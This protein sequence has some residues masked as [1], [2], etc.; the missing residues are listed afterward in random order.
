MLANFDTLQFSASGFTTKR[1]VIG[2]ADTTVDVILDA[3]DRWGGLKN[4]PARSAGCG[5]PTTITSGNK[6]ITSGGAAR[7]YIVDLP[8]NYN[9]DKPYRLIYVSHGMGGQANDVATFLN[10]FGVK[11]EA[12]AAKDPAVLIAMN[13]IGGR[14]GESDHV[15]FDDVTNFVFKG[16]CID[17]TR[18]FV[19]GMSMGG[20]FSYSLSTDRQ[21]RIRAGVGIAPTNYNIWLPNP[22]LK[23]P[24]PWMQT[25]GN[26]DGFC[27]WVY[28]A[29]QKLGAKF[30]A[31]EKAADNGC[32][33]PSEVPFWKSGPHLC[34]DFTGCKVGYPVK[35]C[36]FQ[37]GHDDN[38]R[39][40]G[41]NVNWI[42]AESWKFMT[43]F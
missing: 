28:N 5:K 35:A 10:W 24:I 40:P 26:N 3:A 16:L 22:K 15:L 8:T 42:A 38:A 19:T 30:I 43:Q 17:T 29:A 31:L 7:N 12:T 4:P 20:M 39:D 18:V 6:T 2:S 27:P 33:I 1:I 32:T 25:T 36:T 23:D 41:S 13:A 21:K 14:W 34:Y 37:G 11:G 9:P